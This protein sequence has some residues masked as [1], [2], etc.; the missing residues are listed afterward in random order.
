LNTGQAE[1]QAAQTTPPV[2]NVANTAPP[3]VTPPVQ[4]AP[5][6]PVA[7]GPSPEAVAAL[8]AAGVDPATVFPGYVG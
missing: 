5:A 4:Q 6:Q 3:E 8:R 7:N 1:R 2:T